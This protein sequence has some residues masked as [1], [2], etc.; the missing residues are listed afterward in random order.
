MEATLEANLI[1]PIGSSFL[2]VSNKFFLCTQRTSL[3]FLQEIFMLLNG[4]IDQKR[5]DEHFS[6]NLSHPFSIKCNC[7]EQCCLLLPLT[8]VDFN[9]FVSFI[10]CPHEYKPLNFVPLASNDISAVCCPETVEEAINL[11][12][13]R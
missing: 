3:S 10:L 2:R 11:H 5:M 9:L 6:R 8:H 1:A 4:T 13:N 7:K 12:R